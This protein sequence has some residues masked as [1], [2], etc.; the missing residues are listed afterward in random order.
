M[1]LGQISILIIRYI[2]SVSIGVSD[3]LSTF[4]DNVIIISKCIMWF[5]QSYMYYNA[6]AFVFNGKC[7]IWY[8][9][10]SKHC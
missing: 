10:S 8:Y 1:S 2:W 9:I 3:I 4:K 7:L 5:A 6:H